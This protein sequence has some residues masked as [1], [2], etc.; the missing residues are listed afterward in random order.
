MPSSGAWLDIVP[1][2]TAANEF[3]SVEFEVAL[4]RRLGLY[5]AHAEPT[6]RALRDGA[7]I[8]IDFFG[9]SIANGGEY[10]KRHNAVNRAAI[11]ALA[12]V[13]IG[14]VI[15]GDKGS[16]EATVHLNSSH[17]VD[18]AEIGGDEETG[19]DCLYET[20]CVSPLTQSFTAGNGSSA[21]G[22]APM[23][24]GHRVAFGNT[25]E[26]YRCLVF[27]CRERGK[28]TQG[29]LNHSTGKGWV[30]AR[31][32]QY[33]DALSKK[34]KVCL[35]LVES[36]GGIYFA[37]KKQLYTLSERAA[38]V[39]A[40]D[41]T[42]YGRAAASPRIFMQHHS[43]RLSRAAVM[44]D[45]AAICKKIMAHKQHACLLPRSPP[46]PPIDPGSNSYRPA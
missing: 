15:L 31:A 40:T 22:G 29:A 32:G 5:R 14:P 8:K 9:D 7:H 45:A 19:G 42:R 26:Q 23:S 4:Q 18:I 37:T 43:Q 24:V 35:M 12:A 27:G 17:V 38:G 28:D 36:F 25:A 21:K 13:A 1:D 33:A 20:K 2:N 34:T 30:Q 3:K 16:P 44:T 46:S 39:S 10:N 11:D 41:R 6:V